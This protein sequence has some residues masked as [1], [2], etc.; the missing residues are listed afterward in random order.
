[1]LA[2]HLLVIYKVVLQVVEEDLAE[3]QV[4]KVELKLL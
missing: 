4:P 3:R 1:M 2:Y